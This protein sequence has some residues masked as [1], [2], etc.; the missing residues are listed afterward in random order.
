[1]GFVKAKAKLATVFAAASAV[2][3]MHGM[4]WMDLIEQKAEVARN[5]RGP[6]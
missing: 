6:P 3:W 1:M 4:G 2:F 5:H